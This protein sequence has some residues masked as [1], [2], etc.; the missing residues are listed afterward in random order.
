VYEISIL[1]S[2][3]SSLNSGSCDAV[4]PFKFS[5]GSEE[6]EGEKE[7]LKSRKISSKKDYTAGW[8]DVIFSSYL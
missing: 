7:N 8:Q 3:H 4:F 1:L 5:R 2:D 6:K